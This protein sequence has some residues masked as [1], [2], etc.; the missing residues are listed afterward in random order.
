[1]Q[2]RRPRGLLLVLAAS[3]LY[4]TAGLFTH[5]LHRD[6]WTIL[7]WRAVFATL[8]LLLWMIV[9]HRGAALRAFALRPR[10]I[11][12]AVPTAISGICYIFAL[13]L[14]TVADV[15]VIYAT[16]PFV[17]AAV[18]WAWTRE[19]PAS[20]TMVASCAALGGVALMMV[21]GFGSGPRLAGMGATLIMNLGFAM[22]LV[23]ARASPRTSTAI[24]TVGTALSGVVA[25]IARARDRRAASGHG[26]A[27][28]LRHPDDRARHGPLHGGCPPDPAGRRRLGRDRRRGRRTSPGMAG[29]RRG[30]RPLDDRRRRGRGLGAALASGPRYPSTGTRGR[31]GRPCLAILLTA[32]AMHISASLRNDEVE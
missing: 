6:A 5:A 19:V 23:N 1:M 10:E 4:S 14:T 25:F 26:S 2:N 12:L 30:G 27:G 32:P 16:L 31:S 28:P 8:F 9:E 24:Y 21:G 3:L 20:R 22:I 15:M 7:A 17:V 29:V 18:A 11:A 13:K